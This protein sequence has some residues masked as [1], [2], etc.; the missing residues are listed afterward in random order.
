MR[1]RV[2][3]GEDGARRPRM[4]SAVQK[5]SFAALSGPPES[6]ARVRAPALALYATSFFPVDSPNPGRAWLARDFEQRV[7]APWR[8]ASVARVQRELGGVTVR[9][10]DGATQFSI[11]VRNVVGLAAVIDTFLT[12][13][14]AGSAAMP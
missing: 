6:Y 1:D 2:V 14:G 9:R 13:E 8:A 4:P 10:L 7:A 12:N 5:E 3:I 11:G